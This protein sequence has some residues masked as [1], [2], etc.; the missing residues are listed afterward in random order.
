MC[1]TLRGGSG[2]A[3]ALLLGPPGPAIQVPRV[4]GE[5]RLAASFALV[6]NGVLDGNGRFT[7]AFPVPNIPLLRAFTFRWQRC[8]RRP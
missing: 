7:L 6:S 5:F 2:N 3:F 4:L 1:F 8:R